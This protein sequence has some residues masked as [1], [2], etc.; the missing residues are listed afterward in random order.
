MGKKSSDAAAMLIPEK[1]SPDAR[2][3]IELIFMWL[4]RGLK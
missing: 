2:L 3:I 4:A 1:T